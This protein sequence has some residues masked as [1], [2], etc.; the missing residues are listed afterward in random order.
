M[1]PLFY[2]FFI[3]EGREK[4]FDF[5]RKE[6]FNAATNSFPRDSSSLLRHKDVYICVYIWMPGKRILF[7]YVGGNETKA[8]FVSVNVRE[9]ICAAIT[10]VS[11]LCDARS[12]VAHPLPRF[13]NFGSTSV[14]VFIIVYK[15]FVVIGE[16]ER[17]VFLRTNFGRLKWV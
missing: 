5:G 3:I 7:E 15:S 11:G 13:I 9:A 16:E 12:F 8:D 2:T 10:R 1:M 4:R 6:D 17:L 14:F